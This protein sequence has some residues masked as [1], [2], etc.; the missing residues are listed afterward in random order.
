LELDDMNIRDVIKRITPGTVLKIKVKDT[1][2]KARVTNLDL[3]AG[4]LEILTENKLDIATG[5]NIE[6]TLDEEWFNLVVS[7]DVEKLENIDVGTRLI[8]RMHGKIVLSQ[9]RTQVRY[10]VV[11][12]ATLRVE[13]D[14][15]KCTILDL[16][17]EGLG[18]LVNRSIPKD[19]SIEI[20]LG[21]RPLKG[22]VRSVAQC[23]NT[24]KLGISCKEENEILK[25]MVTKFSE[26]MNERGIKF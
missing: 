14:E 25:K 10:P 19:E 16:S 23:G 5:E 12:P 26:I 17:F 21:E 4:V 9:K 2:T 15:I 20:I 18:I 24:Y 13:E 7:A 11:M 8:A 3:E 1:E 6:M 22:I